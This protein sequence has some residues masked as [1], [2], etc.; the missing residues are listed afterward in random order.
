[1]VSKCLLP[2]ETLPFILRTITSEGE[3]TTPPG[4]KASY[5]QML[6]L[7]KVYTCLNRV[8]SFYPRG[9][10]FL[11]DCVPVWCQHS[12]IC[13][14]GEGDWQGPPPAALK[15]LFGPPCHSPLFHPVPGLPH[16]C[17]QAP[18]LYARRFIQPLCL[19]TSVSTSLQASGLLYAD[20]SPLLM[21]AKGR[22]SLRSQSSGGVPEP[23]K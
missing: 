22:T 12:Y 1:M 19:H 7:R 4:K 16:S 18:N 14:F 6:V 11:C 20:E 15:I 9:S 8:F 17:I 23:P 13:A 10:R 3:H 2:S 21:G 5:S